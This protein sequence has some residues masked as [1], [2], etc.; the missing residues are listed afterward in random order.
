MTT[1]QVDNIL[2]KLGD[3]ALLDNF[4]AVLHEGD[5]LHILYPTFTLLHY[6]T[7]IEFC[8][9]EELFFYSANNKGSFQLT[10]LNDPVYDGE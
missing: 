9:E 2:E 3:T 8:A 5:L 6:E 7:L 10:L 1:Q 4:T